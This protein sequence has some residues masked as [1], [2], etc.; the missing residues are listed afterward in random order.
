MK[1]L[2]TQYG[3]L[4]ESYY[5]ININSVKLFE[6]HMARKRCR[7][8]INQHMEKGNKQPVMFLPFKEEYKSKGKHEHTVSLY[9]LGL[10][11]Q[12]G[13]NDA[14]LLLKKRLQEL[15][16]IE[17]WYNFKYTWFLGCLLHDVA[18][19][20]E[21]NKKIFS[22]K[23]V[24]NIF[25][26]KTKRENVD[27]TSFSEET[28]KNYLEYRN[29]HDHGIVGGY[30]VFDRL[31]KTFKRRTKDN[32]WRYNPCLTLYK[33]GSYILYREEH[34]DHF[35]YISDA[36]VCHNIWMA[37][38]EEKKNLYQEKGLDE[39]VINCDN[40]RLNI[41]NYPLQ[42]ILCLLDTIEPIKRFRSLDAKTVLENVFIDIWDNTI[43]IGCSPIIR[44]Q[45]EFHQW[46][47]NIQEM[48][49]W[50]N[51]EVSKCKNDGEICYKEI[52]W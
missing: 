6:P 48:G 37:Y 39:L 29:Q 9:L 27:I 2:Y 47:A 34:L 20:I 45:D 23:Y 1:S 25:Y 5:N 52:K 41:N 10:L 21:K 24:Y 4:E 19:C 14:D 18:S 33:N 15:M 8:F 26:H 7:K 11:L 42:F 3:E 22:S 44:E 49:K 13:S 43:K 51:V 12:M 40:D 35:A 50:M 31:C 46:F 32:Q 28:V 36:I 16:D 38:D 17:E 30:L